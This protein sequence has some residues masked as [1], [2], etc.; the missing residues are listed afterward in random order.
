MDLKKIIPF[1]IFICFSIS[2]FSQ[3]QAEIKAVFDKYER[4]KGTV[5]VQLSQDVLSQGCNL[6]LYKS[7]SFADI[8][9]EEKNN[10]LQSLLLNKKQ[11][12][13]ISEVIKNG[14]IQSG[15]YSL[16]KSKNN[17]ESY[18]LIKSNNNKLNVVYIVGDVAPNQL[19]KELKKLKQLFIYSN[20]KK[21]NID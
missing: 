4:R 13:V 8:E 14:K 6:H 7:L 1:L 2:A 16:G 3:D 18:L 19:E 9:D 17:K 21:I 5:A 15:S 10:I 11:Y 12:S 20:N